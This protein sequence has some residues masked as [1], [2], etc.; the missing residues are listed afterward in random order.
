MST[1]YDSAYWRGLPR[2]GS[3][4]LSRLLPDSCE[5]ALHRHHVVPISLGGDPL[6]ETVLVCAR[7][8]P[9]LEAL[10]RRVIRWRSCKHEHRTREAR[11]SCERRL[12][13]D[14]LHSR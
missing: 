8:H 7:H 9:A 10:A 11:E 1:V 14:A 2:T 6:G 5:G 12:N 3:C 4:C 13:R